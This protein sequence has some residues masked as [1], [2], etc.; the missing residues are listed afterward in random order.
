MSN[1]ICSCYILTDAVRYS[2]FGWVQT[3]SDR[4]DMRLERLERF[5]GLSH[6]AITDAQL[7]LH[8]SL[9]T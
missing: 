9:L 6:L 8:L 3:C 7:H 2:S 5:G 4:S 1:Y